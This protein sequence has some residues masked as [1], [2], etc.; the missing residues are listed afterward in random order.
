MA[1]QRERSGTLSKNRKC[2]HER[3]PEYRGSC[4]IDGVEYW[5]SAWIK[6]GMDGKFFSLAFT[7]KE[8][9]PTREALASSQAPSN[10]G[11]VPRRDWRRPVDDEIPF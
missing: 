8:E 1:E 2:E 6:E 4:M 10:G 9:R 11:A 3:Q 5:I 7:P